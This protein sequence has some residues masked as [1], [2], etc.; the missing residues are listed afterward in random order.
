MCIGVPAQ[1]IEAAGGMA[2]CR[3]ANGEEHISMLLIGEQPV[4]TWVLTSLGLAREVI[5]AEDA[6]NINLALEGLNAI[7]QGAEEIDV[8][9]YFPG[10]DG[11]R[12]AS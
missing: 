5:S 8:D 9:R 11:Q 3:G 1:V 6:A 7:M 10:L 2:L 12:E 4:G